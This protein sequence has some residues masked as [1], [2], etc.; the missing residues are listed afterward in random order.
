MALIIN[1]WSASPPPGS[2]LASLILL[3]PLPRA[4]RNIPGLQFSSIEH[5]TGALFRFSHFF[6]FYYQHCT[7]ASKSYCSNTANTE[8]KG[9]VLTGT[10]SLLLP[11]LRKV[12]HLILCLQGFAASLNVS[13][14]IH[15]LMHSYSLIPS[16]RVYQGIHSAFA[17]SFSISYCFSPH[18][19][20]E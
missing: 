3:H 20:L 13:K 4:L 8:L 12:V 18:N 6:A 14:A 7:I 16:Q 5:G 11:F 1:L 17:F 19:L 10:K 9:H 2:L 15:S